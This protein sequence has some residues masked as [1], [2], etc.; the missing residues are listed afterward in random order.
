[1]QLDDINKISDALMISLLE[2]Y[3]RSL[4]CHL[5]NLVSTLARHISSDDISRRAR[6][7]RALVVSGHIDGTDLDRLIL[8]T[9]LLDESLAAYNSA[10]SS[11]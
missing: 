10:S 9:M 3:T 4:R 5:V 6:F 2:G 8:K 1:M 7:E 11:I